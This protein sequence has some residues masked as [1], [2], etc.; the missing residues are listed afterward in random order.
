MTPRPDYD[1]HFNAF[2]SSDLTTV[3][4]SA[5]SATAADVA[6]AFRRMYE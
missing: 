2:E 4:L 1:A 5:E 3:P 6:D